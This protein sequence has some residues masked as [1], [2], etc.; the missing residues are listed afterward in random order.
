[1][2]VGAC[3]LTRHAGL[4]RWSGPD[5]RKEMMSDAEDESSEDEQAAEA[6]R[7]AVRAGPCHCELLATAS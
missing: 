2:C 6:T 3:N 5:M 7:Q 1:M 4:G